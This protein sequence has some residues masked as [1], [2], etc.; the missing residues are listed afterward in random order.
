MNRQ[1]HLF[2][3][4][5]AEPA[6][7]DPVNAALDRIEADARTVIDAGGQ[8]AL[9]LRLARIMGAAPQ[10]APLSTAAGAGRARK[11]GARS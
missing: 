9:R 2:R 8:E 3:H 7:L 11:A 5:P 1:L 6:Q 10:V 4:E